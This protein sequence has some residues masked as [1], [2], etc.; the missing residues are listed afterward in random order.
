MEY[1][2]L[3]PVSYG[4]AFG[5]VWSGLVVWSVIVNIAVCISHLCI[6]QGE[7]IQVA[8]KKI[9]QFV[10]QIVTALNE[11]APAVCL[12][13]FLQVHHDDDLMI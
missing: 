3:V 10:H 7:E 6:S 11:Q 9:L 2:M 5:V 4:L 8:S 13:L 1:E 12:R